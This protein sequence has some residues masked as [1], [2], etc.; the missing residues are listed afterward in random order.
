[1]LE[2]SWCKESDETVNHMISK[3]SKLAKKEYK[4]K[5]DWVGKE[6]HWELCKRLNIN[7][8]EKWYRHR[9]ESI[10]ENETYR[11]L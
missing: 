11:I 9:Q 3:H 10:L 5:H 7:H 2:N 8:T 4:N 1:M 6:I